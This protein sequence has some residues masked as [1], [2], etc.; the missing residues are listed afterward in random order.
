MSVFKCVPRFPQILLLGL[1]AGSV[2]VKDGLAM[3]E[4]I[5]DQGWNDDIPIASFC[6]PHATA[7][8]LGAGYCSL[9][10]SASAIRCDGARAAR[11][12]G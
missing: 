11:E 9:G 12:R 6:F 4:G 5:Q 8:G 7:S 2:W 1:T 3:D 10:D